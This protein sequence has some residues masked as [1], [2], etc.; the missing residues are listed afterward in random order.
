VI[1]H[2]VIN[3]VESPS[4]R[5]SVI[6]L[7]V[8][9]RPIV[10]PTVIGSTTRPTTVVNITE[11]VREVHSGLMI[12]PDPFYEDPNLDLGFEPSLYMPPVVTTVVLPSEHSS[13]QS[14]APLD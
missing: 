12:E 11:P 3:V 2:E 1:N 14:S 5:P 9:E 8:V 4:S 10:R 13:W 6:K 7:N